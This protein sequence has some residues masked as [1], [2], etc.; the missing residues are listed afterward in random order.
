SDWATSVT[1]AADASLYV[2]LGST[3]AGEYITSI[4][5]TSGEF[6]NDLLTAEGQV[7]QDSN[8][9][10]DFETETTES[11]TIADYIG[12]ACA[13]TLNNAG[14]YKPTTTTSG[15]INDDPYEGN[16]CLRFGKDATSSITMAS[17]KVDG[18]KTLSFFAHKWADSDATASINIDYSIDGGQSWTTAGVAQ[19]TGTSWEEFSADINVN[20]PV[21]FRLAQTAGARVNIDYIT[22]TVGT[23]SVADLNFSDCKVT[24]IRGGV[25][26]EAQQPQDVKIYGIDGIVYVNTTVSGSQTFTL[27]KGGVYLIAVGKTMQ[28]VV[29]R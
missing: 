12:S 15:T 17:D 20:C 3:T 10:E 7:Y 13:W 28:R 8:F 16:Y 24:P 4:R 9:V 29:I 25:S 19:V 5:V 26:V 27:P 22:A 14:T 6:F 1:A 2:R 18:A 23:S 11:Y 21:R